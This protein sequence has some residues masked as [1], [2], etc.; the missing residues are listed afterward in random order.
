[1]ALGMKLSPSAACAWRFRARPYVTEGYAETIETLQT[2][3][4]TDVA[5]QITPRLLILSPEQE[6]FWPEQAE[7]L[8]ELTSDS[9]EQHQLVK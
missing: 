4:A 5:G 2:F 7:Q 1:M 3:E 9:G 8:A 6:Q